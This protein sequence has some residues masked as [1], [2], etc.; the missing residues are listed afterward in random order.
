MSRKV[1]TLIK[2]AEMLIGAFRSELQKAEQAL[3]GVS[4]DGLRKSGGAVADKLREL[5]DRLDRVEKRQAA[6]TEEPPPLQT[7][8]F[9]FDPPAMLQ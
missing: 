5:E 3:N 2:Q 7:D 1:D 4:G 8:A 9:I 6:P